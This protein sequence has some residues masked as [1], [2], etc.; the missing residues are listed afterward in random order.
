MINEFQNIEAEQIILTKIIM[1]NEAANKVAD[2]LEPKHFSQEVHKQMFEHIIII[3]ANDKPVDLVIMKRFFEEKGG[4]KAYLN[5]IIANSGIL[6]ARDYA[7]ELIELWR[8]REFN[9]IL[10]EAKVLIEGGESVDKANA[11][12]ENET[13]NLSVHDDVRG[14][15]HVSSVI[16]VIREKRRLNIKPKIL[17]TGFLALDQKLNGG[18]YSKQLAIIGARTAV[19][20]TTMMQDIALRAARN[21]KKCLFISLEVDA[22]RVVFKFL[23]NIAS[24]ASWKIGKNILKPHEAQTVERAEKTLSDSGLF[25]NDSTGM[26]AKDIE[27][28]IKNKITEEPV[29]AVFIDYVQH[30]TYENQNTNSATMEISKNVVALKAMAQK[31]DVAMI[32]AAQINRAGTEK[33]TL[34]HFEG[35]SAIEKNADVALIIHRAEVP[36]DQRKDSYYSM[37]GSWIVAKNRDGGSGEIN[38]ELEGEFGR[39]NEIEGF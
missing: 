3:L 9:K 10:I 31:F 32:A 7:I 2:I 39:F 1:N 21:G 20:K 30:I 29:D 22:E 34:A 35:S 24:I 38:F 37:C 23:S 17:S 18:F 5:Q 8:K 13:A 27:R 26:T 15:K 28:L 16:D 25:I 14:T 33:P 12:V 11:F 4:D 19:G 36:E 6:R